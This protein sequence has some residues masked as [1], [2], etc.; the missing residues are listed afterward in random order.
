MQSRA[1]QALRTQAAGRGRHRV[2]RVAAT[3]AHDH[4][5]TEAAPR[6]VVVT[7]MGLVSCLA[8]HQN[9]SAPYYKHPAPSHEH[10]EFYNNL[11]AGKSGISHI[12]GF[13][14]TDYT[15]RFAGEIK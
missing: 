12:E 8:C 15:T 11:L 1:K 7:G 2:V 10:D 3:A 13:N 6:R 4:A 14:T 9:P 5:K